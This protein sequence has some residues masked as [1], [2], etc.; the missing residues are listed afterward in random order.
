MRVA[1]LGLGEAGSIYAADLAARGSTVR[2]VD[3]RVRAELPGVRQV[4][5]I[6]D[7]VDGAEVVLSLVGGEAST[8]AMDEALPAM[9]DGA[10]YA[11]LNTSHPDTQRALAARAA[12]RG[13][14]FSDVAILAPVGRARIDTDLLV[15]GVATPHL[16]GALRGVG[17]P[18][19][20]AGPDAGAAAERKL[21]RSVFMKGVAALVFESATAAEKVGARDWVMGQIA[22]EFG[23]GGEELVERMLEGTRRHAVRRAAEMREVRSYL[24][25]LEAAHPM[26]DGTIAWLERIAADPTGH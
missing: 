9:A 19:A 8:A 3:P 2:G 12:G 25:S 10:L 18:A 24:G 20:D 4:P 14:P 5:T 26:T 6:A 23:D 15:S 13:I 17:I 7:A 22:A 21:L 16:L 11:D 1:V